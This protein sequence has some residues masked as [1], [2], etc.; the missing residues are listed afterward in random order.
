[1]DAN[2]QIP[3]S[4]WRLF[5]SPNRELYI[6]AMLQINEEYEYNNYFLSREVCIQVLGDYFAKK[7]V[8]LEKEE[9]ETD[10]DLLEPPASRTLNWLLRAQW[11]KRIE[12]YY[13][14]VTHIVIPDYA[15]IFVDAFTKIYGEE[16]EETDLYIQNIYAILFSFQNDEKASLSL[17]KTALVNTRRLNK[18]LQNLLHNMDRFFGRLLEKENYGE[19]L[20][21]HLE[22]YV[23]EI[24]RK[25]YHI[26][27]TSDNFYLYKA[28]IKKWI[29]KMQE[30]PHWLME[31]IEKEKNGFG[32]EDVF[33]ILDG[34]ERGFDDI[35]H[36][37]AN[38]DREHIRYVRAT[39]VRL[40]YLLNGEG[41][42]KGL[43]NRLL[44]ALSEGEKQE[45]RIK[46]V[47]RQFNLSDPVILSDTSFY[48]K[49]GARKKFLEEVE[50][51]Q[52]R[53]ELT[54]EEILKLN[55]VHNRYTKQQIEIFLEEREENGVVDTRT[56]PIENGED[57][58]KLILAYDNAIKRNSKYKVVIKGEQ[59]VNNGIFSYP[60][61]LFVRK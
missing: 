41:D 57:F 3:D 7:S 35:E 60:D 43:V 9:E 33:Q 45:E 2:Y 26:L 19:L 53:T 29:H 11:L 25:K 58:E 59:R 6:E 28:D 47:S 49:R 18:S 22:G 8:R 50:P 44:L 24:I 61:L 21:D 5:R 17:L 30:N 48:Q 1:M 56:C 40:Q 34:I 16:E 27:K 42:T 20:R 12:D 55:R 36:R 4:F 52:K 32:Q 39:V 10:L 23:E 54:R 51:E 31:K 37:I 15:A 46:A 14:Q 13:E 38:M